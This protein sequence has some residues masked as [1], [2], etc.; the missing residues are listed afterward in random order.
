MR[1]A[2]I[3]RPVDEASYALQMAMGFLEMLLVRVRRL[4]LPQESREAFA[5]VMRNRFSRVCGS[6]G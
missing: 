3:L 2:S 5:L 1:A 6:D 4:G